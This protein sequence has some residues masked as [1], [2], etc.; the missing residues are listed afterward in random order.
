MRVV[1]TFVVR[2]L[3]DTEEPGTLRGVVRTVATAQDHTFTDE[4]M[5][6]KLLRTFGKAPALSVARASGLLTECLPETKA[7]IRPGLLRDSVLIP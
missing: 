6:L 7:E 5:L 1:H 4:A 3:M 2:L